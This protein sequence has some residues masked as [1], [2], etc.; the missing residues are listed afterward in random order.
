MACEEEKECADATQDILHFFELEKYDRTSF[1]RMARKQKE[2][3]E[4]RRKAKDIKAQIE[5]VKQWFDSK[6]P[7]VK[8]L[9]QVLGALRKAEKDYNRY[10]V[11]VPKTKE[12]IDFQIHSD[13]KDSANK[14]GAE[15]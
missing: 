11:Y 14:Y 13:K 5:P 6:Q 15:E 1:A 9:E 10:R 7:Q 3:R 12:I 2:V 8:E 4:R